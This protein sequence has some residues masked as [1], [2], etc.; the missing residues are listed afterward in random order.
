MP[1]EKYCIYAVFG[2][3]PPEKSEDMDEKDDY[4]QPV[5]KVCAVDKEFISGKRKYYKKRARTVS[6]YAWKNGCLIQGNLYM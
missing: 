5:H 2:G 6:L 4:V 1:N 3:Y